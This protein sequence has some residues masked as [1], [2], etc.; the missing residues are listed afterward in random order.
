VDN[1]NTIPA[2]E[3][4]MEI[5]ELLSES[6]EEQLGIGFEEILKVTGLPRSTVFRILSTLENKAFV[7]KTTQ[8]KSIRW[9]IG[10]GIM[11]IGLQKISKMDIRSEAMPIM[12]WLSD[13]TDEYVQ[14]GVLVQGKVMYVEHVKRLKKL[15]I[16]AE[17]GS[18]LHVN[19]S[20]AG[21][22]LTSDLSS[23][24]IDQ[25]IT[26]NG[27][28]QNTENTITTSEKFKAELNSVKSNGFAIDDEMYAIG[29]RCIAAPI[30]DYSGKVVA[31]IGISALANDVSGKELENKKNAVIDA[32]YKVSEILGFQKK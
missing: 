15:S 1:K 11:R 28:P 14:L 23:T 5:L 9:K 2:I 16:Y 13:G 17:L 25:I 31:A 7:E 19:L 27:L 18:L 22:V 10:K 21:M 29:I 3:R 4:A 8:E 20:A 6:G 12:K 32:G 24:L 30:Y 26:D